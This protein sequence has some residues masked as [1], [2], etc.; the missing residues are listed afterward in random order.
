MSLSEVVSG[1]LEPVFDLMPRIHPKPA[2]NRVLVVDTAWSKPKVV[3]NRPVL[4][5]PALSVVEEWDAVDVPLDLGSQA[6]RTADGVAVVVN[7]SVIVEFRQ[8]LVTRAYCTHEDVETYVG[9]L[10]RQAVQAAITG[11]NLSHILDCG[12]DIAG[13]LAHASLDEAGI[14]LHSLVFEEF[15]TADTIR[16]IGM[17]R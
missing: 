15:T 12:E 17:E 8:P 13:D 6:L 4:Y 9:I 2:S 7:A 3:R 10:S 5:V 1:V 16:L 11:H 14:V